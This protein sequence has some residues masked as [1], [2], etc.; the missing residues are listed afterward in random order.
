MVYKKYLIKDSDDFQ[1]SQFPQIIE[2]LE[3]IIRATAGVSAVNYADMLLSICKGHGMKAEW[4]TAH[5]DFAE[6]ISTQSLPVKNLEALFDSC[7]R[8]PGFERQLEAYIRTSL[9][10]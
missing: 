2:D 4:T 6:K 10:V 9:N 5:P 8:N 3:E 1:A 7:S